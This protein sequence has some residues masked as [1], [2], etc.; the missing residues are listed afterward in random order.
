M[1]V[2]VYLRCWVR[3]DWHSLVARTAGSSPWVA[4]AARGI[5]SLGS[6]RKVAVHAVIREVLAVVPLTQ[7]TMKWNSPAVVSA[8]LARYS[9]WRYSVCQGQVYIAWHAVWAALQSNRVLL[10]KASTH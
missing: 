7:L 3:S 4:R 9:S 10:T 6:A 1:V 2:H 8:R 5:W